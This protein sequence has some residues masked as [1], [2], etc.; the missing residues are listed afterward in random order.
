MK[1]ASYDVGEI[2]AITRSGPLWATNTAKGEEALICMRSQKDSHNLHE[3]WKRW[4]KVQNTHVVRLIDIIQCDDGRVALIQER[5]RGTRLDVLM[6]TGALRESLQ[7]QAYIHDICEAVNA[8]HHMGIAHTDL[9]PSNVIC[10]PNRGAVLIDLID[11]VP[12][13]GGTPQW[14]AECAGGQNGD[15]EAV[16]RIAYALG[17]HRDGE[18]YCASLSRENSKEHLNTM[19]SQA[20]RALAPQSDFSDNSPLTL[21]AKT[22]QF[23]TSDEKERRKIGK[24]GND[25]ADDEA[26]ARVYS[27]GKEIDV[28]HE[29]EKRASS[30]PVRHFDYVL[31]PTRNEKDILDNMRTIALRTTTVF[32]RE[33]HVPK[34]L[35]RYRKM[36]RRKKPHVS[37]RPHMLFSGVIL[38]LVLIAAI[39]MHLP[40][41]GNFTHETQAI[42]PDMRNH[43]GS[44]EN[45]KLHTL[46]PLAP[47]KI[48]NESAQAQGEERKKARSIHMKNNT[49]ASR[50]KTRGDTTSHG[51][52]ESQG[53]KRKN[54]VAQPDI[55]DPIA[56][57]EQVN[58][59]LS[60]RDQAMSQ[61]NPQLLSSLLTGEAW[62]S[63]K[64]IIE[65]LQRSH[66]L[67]GG[68]HT[69]GSAVRITQCASQEVT[70]RLRVKQDSYQR[71]DDSACSQVAAEEKEML[72]LMTGESMQLTQVRD[73]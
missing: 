61:L 36:A 68:F 6:K 62:E 23:I 37:H 44:T 54:T 57:S 46:P 50:E 28:P 31:D 10:V 12:A 49:Q 32:P 64:K 42:S 17:L 65:A 2:V 14:S 29:S 55:C 3:R 8:L 58:A 72:W 20:P 11:E 33:R 43:S 18:A 30:R 67:L 41:E 35:V 60:V 69:Q 70:L 52:D 59:I 56:V 39:W 63:D 38:L 40:R 71:C 45:T 26:V 16:E 4:Q 27:P 47:G 15:Q 51:N 1:I 53:L 48:P 34:G 24:A 22:P 5:L 7:R 25:A 73:I 19:N 13:K 21:R 9:S 66:T